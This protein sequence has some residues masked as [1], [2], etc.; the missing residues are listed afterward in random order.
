MILTYKCCQCKE[1]FNL[2]YKVSDRGELRKQ[3]KSL[4]EKCS[5][6]KCDNKIDINEIKAK[7]SPYIN[8]MYLYALIVNISIGVLV[9]F[10]SSLNLKTGNSHWQFL[11]A[12]LIFSIPFVIAKTIINNELNSVRIF[13]RYYL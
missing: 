11:G 13:N 10:F 2:P 12:F 4:K 3:N 1:T 9:Y 6:C 8:F 5:H 7:T